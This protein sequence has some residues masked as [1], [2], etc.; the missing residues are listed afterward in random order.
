MIVLCF[1]VGGTSI[2]YALMD[3]EA[4]ILEKGNFD[5]TTDSMESFLSS[6]KEVY[7]SYKDGFISNLKILTN[8]VVYDFDTDKNIKLTNEFMGVMITWTLSKD[9]YE[10]WKKS[11]L[12]Y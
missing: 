11:L 2:K 3:K 10:I 9:N 8:G 6:I 5:A 7:E 12:E 4:K 1:D